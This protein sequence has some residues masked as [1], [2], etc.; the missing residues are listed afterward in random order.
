[1]AKIKAKTTKIRKATPKKP[2]KYKAHKHYFLNKNHAGTGVYWYGIHIH[3]VG[4]GV[5]AAGTLVLVL[6]LLNG[7]I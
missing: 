5:A 7:I 2:A 1:M 4:L 3:H 6:M